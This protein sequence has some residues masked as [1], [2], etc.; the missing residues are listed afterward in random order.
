MKPSR[1]FSLVVAPFLALAAMLASGFPIAGKPV[2]MVVPFPPG[3]EAADATARV[4]A[5]RL[6]QALDV[7]VFVEN[8]PGGG[9]VIGNQAV[10]SAA[11]RPYAP[12]RGLD[13]LHYAAA[14]AQQASVR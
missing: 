14:S 8:R 4:V 2:R 9:T 1:L 10:A 6:S 11:G 13:V 7:P 5:Q 3:A 12:L